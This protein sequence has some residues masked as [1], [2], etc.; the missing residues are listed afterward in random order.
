MIELGDLDLPDAVARAVGDLERDID[1]QRYSS[2]GSNGYLF[3]GHH[4]ILGSQVAIKFYYWE[5]GRHDEPR[6]LAQIDHD[7]VMPV[8]SAHFVDDEWAMFQTPY[9]PRGDLEQVVASG[10]LSLHQ[11]IEHV[12]EVLCGLSELHSAGLLHR[13]LKPANIFVD[14]EGRAQI[15]DFGS[16]RAIPEGSDEVVGSGH[17]ALY[18]PPESFR[19]DTYS[20]LGDVYQCGIVLFQLVGGSLPY[21]DTHWLDKEGKKCWD[22]AGDDAFAKSKCVDDSIER[23]ARRRKLL[24]RATLPPTVPPAMVRALRKATHP[25]PE[26]RF[27]SSAH[28]LSELSN[29][30]AKTLDWL[31]N[32]DEAHTIAVDCRFRVVP[33]GRGLH[34]AECDKGSG[35]RR[36]QGLGDALP[37][38]LAGALNQRGR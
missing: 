13:D 35:W 22:A 36:V 17:S 7:N 32:Q 27:R 9:Y 37:H 16:V 31:W 6:L 19:D 23:L 20:K 1:V 4:R 29:I 33:A 10:N 26:A 3:F 12:V 38:D 21:E 15:G 25:A 28:F 14:E 34:R 11:A 8:H 30:R 24:D 2:K 5:G 18:R